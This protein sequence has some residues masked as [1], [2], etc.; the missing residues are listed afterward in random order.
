MVEYRLPGEPC[1]VP[2]VL[3][4]STEEELSAAKVAVY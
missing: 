1:L 2:T 4:S 3:V